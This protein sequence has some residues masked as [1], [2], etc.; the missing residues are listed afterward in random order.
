MTN[1]RFLSAMGAATVLLVLAAADSA[2]AQ[3]VVRA[4]VNPWTGQAYRN[5]VRHNPWTG[6]QVA[7]HRSTNPWT[8]TTV[9][10]GQVFN[11]WTGRT[12]TAG[13]VRNPWTGQS[14]LSV[15]RW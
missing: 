6:R 12:T 8:G 2:D 7:T 10:G 5:V 11:P 1:L 13:V 4:G 9:R 14:H 15:H 3:V